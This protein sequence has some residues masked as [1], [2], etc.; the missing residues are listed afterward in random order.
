MGN[1]DQIMNTLQ[2]SIQQKHKDCCSSFESLDNLSDE[3]DDSGIKLQETHAKWKDS[4]VLSGAGKTLGLTKANMSEDEEEAVFLPRRKNGPRSLQGSREN[5][6]I[7]TGHDTD[8]RVNRRTLPTIHKDISPIRASRSRSPFMNDE[9]SVPSHDIDDQEQVSKPEW[10]K[11]ESGQNLTGTSDV[12]FSSSVL[13]RNDFTDNWIMKQPDRVIE[14]RQL[15]IPRSSSWATPVRPDTLCVSDMNNNDHSEDVY[16]PRFTKNQK[17]STSKPASGSRTRSRWDCASPVSIKH[18]DSGSQMITRDGRLESDGYHTL[19]LKNKS[20]ANNRSRQS[21][22]SAIDNSSNDMTFKSSPNPNFRKGFSLN[23]QRQL[24]NNSD[25]SA[26]AVD[27]QSES[28]SPR[29]R[30]DEAHVGHS[31]LSEVSKSA[32][33][34]IDKDCVGHGHGGTALF[35][36]STDESL[37]VDSPGIRKTGSS[38][39]MKSTSDRHLDADKSKNL[40][41]SPNKSYEAFYVSYGDDAGTQNNTKPDETMAGMTEEERAIKFPQWVIPF[42]DENLA[43]KFEYSTDKRAMVKNKTKPAPRRKVSS[44]SP[45]SQKRSQ[46]PSPAPTRPRRSQA[47][48]PAPTSPR[49]SQAPSPAPTSPRRSQAPSPAPTSPRRSQAPSPALGSPRR[50]QA[51]SPRPSDSGPV[52]PPRVKRTAAM[53]R[54][55]QDKDDL[56]CRERPI[57]EKL[58]KPKVSVKA[59]ERVKSPVRIPKKLPQVPSE[60]NSSIAASTD[61]SEADMFPVHYVKHEK[62]PTVSATKGAKLRTGVPQKPDGIKH[63]QSDTLLSQRARTASRTDLTKSKSKT[64]LSMPSQAAPKSTLASKRAKSMDNLALLSSVSRDKKD[65]SPSRSPG[66]SL[67]SPRLQLY[68]GVSSASTSTAGKTES[69]AMKAMREARSRQTYNDDAT[70]KPG[71]RLSRTPARKETLTSTSSNESRDRRR[72]ASTNGRFLSG[73]STPTEKSQDTSGTRAR[74]RARFDRQDSTESES[75]TSEQRATRPRTHTPV[76]RS[77]SLSVSKEADDGLKDTLTLPR[78]RATAEAASTHPGGYGTLRTTKSSTVAPKKSILKKATGTSAPKAGPDTGAPSTVV[79][80]EPI[81]KS[82][83]RVLPRPPDDLMDDVITD[84]HLN[85]SWMSASRENLS[86]SRSSSRDDLV[87]SPTTPRSRP[88]STS[89]DGSVGGLRRTGYMASKDNLLARSNSK[90]ESLKSATTAKSGPAQSATNSNTTKPRR[91]GNTVEKLQKKLT[92]PTAIKKES[93]PK[94]SPTDN[95][96]KSLRRTGF[97]SSRENLFKSTPSKEQLNSKLSKSRENLLKTSTTKDES[98]KSVKSPAAIRSRMASSSAR[99]ASSSGM[100][101]SSSGRVASSSGMVASSS[102]RV[103]R[104][105]LVS[106]PPEDASSEPRSPTLS[107][108][109]LQPVDSIKVNKKL[110]QSSVQAAASSRKM[111]DRFKKLL[112]GDVTDMS[113]PVKTDGIN[114][115]ENSFDS[116]VEFVMHL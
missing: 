101:A 46:A 48:S 69:R 86:L 19:P 12:G 24:S 35:V 28:V 34:E 60:V 97:T 71:E 37:T 72:S 33:Q 23:A 30:W 44:P 76:R 70:S 49:R 16:M 7:N 65:T 78:R 106:P 8:F 103:A 18:E 14:K 105:R 50:S 88:P 22:T 3:D 99:V 11:W 29:S 17:S 62:P 102:G 112:E 89:S 92:T 56:A 66:N 85:Q 57:P 54:I 13:K 63:S 108:S 31:L 111:S 55:L 26:K 84:C 115:R 94:P 96:I 68:S 74:A 2:E 91:V 58:E 98:V 79:A 39:T 104:Q 114:E 47:P 25:E 81:T 75:N 36:S 15:P 1:L 45:T 109:G 100:V 107:K 4:D 10:N 113:T 27:K 93:S 90:D 87:K 41:D 38:N 59:P 32:N 43:G 77:G 20:A 67:S 5:I 82:G 95:P 40:E 83:K 80:K 42:I 61:G 51:P 73:R 9:G 53:S 6:S 21:S 110:R 64:D 52:A 116:G